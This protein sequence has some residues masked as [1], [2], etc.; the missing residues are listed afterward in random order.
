[1]FDDVSLCNEGCSRLTNCEVMQFTG[2]T[3]KNGR[4]IYEGDLL[5]FEGGS[6]LVVAYDAKTTCFI[7]KE[8]NRE[9]PF[10]H[11]TWWAE[12]EVIGNIYE[13]PELLG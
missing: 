6:P 13:N 4:E 1:M 5:A 8:P 2:L 10:V 9:K 12:P 7:A 3:D 11:I